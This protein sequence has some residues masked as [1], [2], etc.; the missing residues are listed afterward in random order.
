MNRRSLPEGRIVLHE[1]KYGDHTTTPKYGIQTSTANSGRNSINTTEGFDENESVPLLAAAVNSKRPTSRLVRFCNKLSLLLVDGRWRFSLILFVVWYAFAW[2]YYGSVLLTSTIVQNDPHCNVN[3]SFVNASNTNC[4]DSELDTTDFVEIMITSA[5]ELPGIFTN[6]IIIE[7]I[8]RKLTMAFNFTMVAI[9]MSLLFLC[10]PEAV[11]TLLLFVVRTFS[12]AGIQAT[13]VYTA[14]VYP[15][16][17]RGLAMGLLNSVSRLGA[18][19][20]PF[21][22]QVL[23]ETSDY[24]TIGVYT[25]SSAVVVLMA[26]L[27]PVETK[28]KL[29]KD[30]R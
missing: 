20:T 24:A 26:I 2:L 22:A 25:G 28:G 10:P 18:I 3:G 16:V 4:S 9:G 1:D 11:L 15:T 30:K 19:L 6:I 14:E 7:L 12:M 8:G 29:L 27:L 13:Y 17:V 21:V 5:A 23:F